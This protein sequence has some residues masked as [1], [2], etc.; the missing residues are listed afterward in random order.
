[1]A[2]VVFFPR[3]P[4]LRLPHPGPPHRQHPLE[5]PSRP[6]DALGGGHVSSHGAAGLLRALPDVLDLLQRKAG[7]LGHDDERVEQA[8]AHDHCEGKEDG[9]ATEVVLGQRDH[10]V[11]EEG[12]EALDGGD[13]AAADGPEVGGEQLALEEVGNAAVPDCF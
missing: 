3:Q 6:A 5:L 1:M 4:H 12:E 13:E 11:L 9:L 8:K 7:R 10:V 2:V